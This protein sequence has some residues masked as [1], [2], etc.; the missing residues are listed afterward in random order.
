[1]PPPTNQQCAVAGM[2]YALDHNFANP[3]FHHMQ[4]H[5][6]PPIAL[7]YQAHPAPAVPKCLAVTHVV[8]VRV[9]GP[10]HDGAPALI[11]M[12]IN[13]DTIDPQDFLTQVCACMEVE[14]D[15]V[16][17]GWKAFN[18]Q[19]RDAP[20][21]LET[22]DDVQKA[23]QEFQAILDNKRRTKQVHMIIVNQTI[24]PAKIETPKR[25]ET[26]C[27]E[28][29]RELKEALRYDVHVGEHVHMPYEAV[30]LWARMKTQHNKVSGVDNNNLPEC[31]KLD[32]LAEAT[33]QC[34]ELELQLDLIFKS[35]LAVCSRGH[36]RAISEVLDEDEDDKTAAILICTVL[37][38][39]N[40]C[41]P[42]LEY[43]Q[44]EQK[45]CQQGITYVHAIQYF[46]KKFFNKKVSMAPG[47]IDDFILAGKRCM[48]G[49]GK[50]R[51]R[52]E[53]YDLDKEN[54]C[55]S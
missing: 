8:N 1:M 2:Q 37:E 11:L 35:T 19:L 45:L 14:V 9:P 47:S 5:P 46:D 6:Q 21:W 24:E 49:K 4:P 38:E 16:K 31:L 50:K 42:D 30:S 55:P 12:D 43:I 3:G 33:K 28:E 44:Y 27:S 17:L 20:N 36:K 15:K 25:L 40:H 39:L 54:Q 22:V 41:F 18:A 13:I 34:E 48:K 51:S 26:T 29:V 10:T 32:N 52:A 7:Q 23:F 53:N